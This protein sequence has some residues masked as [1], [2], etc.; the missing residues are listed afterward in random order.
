VPK[1]IKK[2]KKIFLFTILFLIL[3]SALILF[4]FFKFKSNLNNNQS[5][6]STSS[7]E[8]LE[9]DWETAS[10]LIKNCQVRVIFQARTLQIN[11]RGYDNQLYY[12]IEPKFND[13]INLAKEVQ[14]PCD[15]IQIVTE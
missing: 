5:T 14:G 12:T 10:N 6:T 13:V 11:L 8:I 15:I 4:T 7:N 2:N 1:N 9:I 3:T